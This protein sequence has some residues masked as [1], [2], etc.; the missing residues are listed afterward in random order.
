MK[1]QIHAQGDAVTPLPDSQVGAW[2]AALREVWQLFEE[3]QGQPH[4]RARRVV[5]KCSS[6]KT[7]KVHILG[8]GGGGV[9]AGK[10]AGGPAAGEKSGAYKWTYA[11]R[12]GTRQGV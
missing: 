6:N 3:S 8:N 7:H 2:Q 5:G 9:G 10:T 1:Y 11:R 12:N 4:P